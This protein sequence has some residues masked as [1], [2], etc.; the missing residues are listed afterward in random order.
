MIQAFGDIFKN[1]F[2]QHRWLFWKPSK[3]FI[4]PAGCLNFDSCYQTLLCQQCWNSSIYF[5]RFHYSLEMLCEF[6][7]KTIPDVLAC[8]REVWGRK[9]YL[10]SIMTVSMAII[11]QK[12]VLFRELDT[13]H[14]PNFFKNDSILTKKNGHD[15]LPI[16]FLTC[17]KKFLPKNYVTSAVANS[18]RKAQKQQNRSAYFCKQPFKMKV[19]KLEFKLEREH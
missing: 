11:W 9:E 7:S 5:G 6:D 13:F 1:T 10:K 16:S 4:V 3:Y 15:Q 19:N 2:P 12:T 17:N 8:S 14:S 18:P